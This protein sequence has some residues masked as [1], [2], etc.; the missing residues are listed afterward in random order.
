[1]RFS[2]G[3]TPVSDESPLK[4][5]AFSLKLDAA[6]RNGL[7]WG[8]NKKGA[9]DVDKDGVLTVLRVQLAI[10]IKWLAAHAGEI[11][12]FTVFVMTVFYLYWKIREA[13]A[14]A[15]TAERELAE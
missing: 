10:L 11:Q 13:R 3:F 2:L 5:R 15:R 14:N 7:K 8:V 12:A 6:G 1:M 9:V 4:R